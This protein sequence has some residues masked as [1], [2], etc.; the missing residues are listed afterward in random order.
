VTDG[1]RGF[2]PPSTNALYRG[3]RASAWFLAVAALFTLVPGLIHSFLPDGGAGVIAGLDMGDRRELVVGVFRWEGASQ[4]AF[5]LAMLA[6][7]I[8]YRPLTPLFLALVLLQATLVAL[9]G[10]VLA[11]PT[12]GHHPPAHYGAVAAALLS[13]VFLALSLRR[14]P[15]GEG[16]PGG[17]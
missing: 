14:W 6:V 16:R 1:S 12:N 2:L 8:R 11:P 5:G 7:A 15:R 3:A 13:A 4:L 10:W 17:A 9:Q